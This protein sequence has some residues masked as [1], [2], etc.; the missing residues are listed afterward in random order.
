MFTNTLIFLGSTESS[1]ID[2]TSRRDFYSLP[3]LHSLSEKFNIN[4]IYRVLSKRKSVD[5]LYEQDS[6]PPENE[7][8]VR[9]LGFEIVERQRR[10]T[11][12]YLLYVIIYQ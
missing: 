4:A 6:E 1:L 5:V 10:F 7:I 2:D 3:A 8:N 11:V 9:I 12:N